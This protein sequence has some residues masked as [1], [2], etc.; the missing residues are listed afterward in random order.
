[1]AKYHKLDTVN[2]D[3]EAAHSPPAYDTPQT[4]AP[5]INHAASALPTPG[6][7]TSQTPATNFISV[8]HSSTKITGDYNIDTSIAA[9]P[10]GRLFPAG[11]SAASTS[12]VLGA[13]TVNAIFQAKDEDIELNL[14]V[15]GGSTAN[16]RVEQKEGYH[17][18]HVWVNFLHRAPSTPLHLHITGSDAVRVSPPSSFRGPVAGGSK[19]CGDIQFSPAFRELGVSTFSVNQQNPLDGK[20]FLGEWESWDREGRGANWVGDRLVVTSE[21]GPVLV[22]TYEEKEAEDEAIRQWWLGRKEW[23]M[24]VM[25]AFWNIFVAVWGVILAI[26]LFLV[27]LAHLD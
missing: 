8:I 2:V 4:D 7:S 19:K 17:S 12:R 9:A 22:Q 3:L 27:S 6:T 26:G 15:K 24:R 21:G 5:I 18:E 10:I 25:L 1:M 23:H 11:S 16:I 20:Y 13:K 14:R